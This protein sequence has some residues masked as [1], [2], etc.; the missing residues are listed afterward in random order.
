M[1]EPP[2]CP[3][4]C[5]ESVERPSRKDDFLRVFP[6][7]VVG[8]GNDEL[9]LSVLAPRFLAI[10]VRVLELPAVCG[11]SSAKE[12]AVHH[13]NLTGVSG[14]YAACAHSSEFSELGRS[15][16][17]NFVH[18]YIRPPFYLRNTRRQ[19]SFF[20]E[21]ELHL[22][23]VCIRQV[24]F[25]SMEFWFSLALEH[26]AVTRKQALSKSKQYTLAHAFCT[27]K[28]LQHLGEIKQ[29]IFWS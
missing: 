9:G 20:G 29:S 10:P 1:A 13:R 14:V 15:L 26:C 11:K 19:K 23:A 16:R 8:E 6:D 21:V 12:A 27:V 7:V 24:P 17:M 28:V 5:A 25:L 18:L 2:R 3:S 22:D 4:E